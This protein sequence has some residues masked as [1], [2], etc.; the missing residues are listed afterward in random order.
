MK[1][2]AKIK[3]VVGVLYRRCDKTECENITSG[4]LSH[5]RCDNMCREAYFMYIDANDEE[6]AILIY[7][8]TDL[9]TINILNWQKN[10]L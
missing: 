8:G 1:K 6:K 4:F 10:S 5:N 9:A 7:N 3:D 2:I